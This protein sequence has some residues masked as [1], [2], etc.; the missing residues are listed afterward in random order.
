[1]NS[2]NN[3]YPINSKGTGVESPMKKGTINNGT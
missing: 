3:E 2:S 1:M